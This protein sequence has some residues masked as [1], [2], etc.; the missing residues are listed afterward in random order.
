MKK[1]NKCNE[2][3]PLTSFHKKK[4]TK[5]ELNGFCKICRKEENK[6]KVKHIYDRKSDL[7][8][9]CTICG[10]NNI[11]CLEFH[12]LNDK[13]SIVNRL[14]TKEDINIE[15]SKCQLLC[16]FCHH[17]ETEHFKN[18]N[19]KVKRN[20]NF[21]GNEKIKIGKCKDCDRKVLITN[22]QAFHFDHLGNKFMNISA[23]CK[24]SYSL[25]TI[26]NEI[27]KCQLLCSNCHKL[28]TI[29]QFNQLTYF[30]HEYTVFS[31]ISHKRINIFT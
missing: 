10:Y 12:H 4:D 21:V 6:N 27:K 30:K 7:G 15:I 22:I 5:D 31:F 13:K 2:L 24:Q 29:K 20:Y 11:L 3:L 16:S 23:L 28:K 18:R 26:E 25:K 17:L 14:N 19:E 9:E 1:C 8:G